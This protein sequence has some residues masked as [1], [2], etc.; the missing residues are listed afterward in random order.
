MPKKDWTPEERQAFADKMKKAREDKLTGGNPVLSNEPIE[1]EKVTIYRSEFDE[2][3]RQIEEIKNN[4]VGKVLAQLLSN[5]APKA[6]GLIGTTEKYSVNPADYPDPRERLANEQKLQQ[7]AFKYH[8]ELGW[9][10]KVVGYETI[11]K[12]R[13]EEPQFILKLIRIV[14]DEDTQEPT[15]KRF[16]VCQLIFHEDPTAAIAIANQNGLPVDKENEKEFLDEMRYLRMRDW[17]FESFYP[18]RRTDIQGKK[19]MVIGN[20]LV[21]VYEINSEGS[22]QI[23]WDKLKKAKL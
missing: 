6:Q 13:M 17:L 3:K 10:I 5:Q 1:E 22:A 20:K 16:I 8:Y 15:N 4:D 21:E 7:F 14:L 19:E 2:I 12:R 9:D 23:P 11:D 18:P